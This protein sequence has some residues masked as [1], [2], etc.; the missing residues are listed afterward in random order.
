MKKAPAKFNKKMRAAAAAGK[1]DKNPKFK[2][3]VMEAPS[4][5]KK[6]SMAMLKK[7]M[8]TLK[9]SMAAMKKKSAMMMKKMEAK[10]VNKKPSKTPAEKE[11]ERR[12]KEKEKNKNKMPNRIG[13]KNKT[14]KKV[15]KPILMKKK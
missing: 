13:P 5:M 15:K 14:I 8:A 1:L 4:K 12:K 11:M 9:K 3:A 7:S 6:G 2:K 10:A